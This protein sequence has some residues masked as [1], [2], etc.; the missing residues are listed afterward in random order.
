MSPLASPQRKSP[1]STTRLT[2]DGT[3]RTASSGGDTHLH[4]PLS[5][6]AGL[7]GTT[8]GPNEAFRIARGEVVTSSGGPE[9]QLRRPHDFIIAL[10]LRGHGGNDK[11]H[12][13]C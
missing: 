1:G 6:D 11:P 7:T 4:T 2:W 9:A 10:D 13:S 12:G 3:S 5:P 8:L